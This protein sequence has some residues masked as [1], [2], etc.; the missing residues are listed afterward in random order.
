MWIDRKSKEGKYFFIFRFKNKNEADFISKTLES[1]AECFSDEDETESWIKEDLIWTKDKLEQ[2][3]N[4]RYQVEDS[5]YSALIYDDEMASMAE[6]LFY[7]LVSY[8]IRS[9]ETEKWKILAGQCEDI[10]EKW[11]DAANNYKS[12]YD[13]LKNALD[14]VFNKDHDSMSDDAD[15]TGEISNEV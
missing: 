9:E 11:K 15:S 13:N 4:D 12:A 2:R 1:V 7:V 3:S 5:T 14:V 10:A 8:S 6:V